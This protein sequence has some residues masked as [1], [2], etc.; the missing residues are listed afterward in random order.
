MFRAYL[1]QSSG[2]Q[3]PSQWSHPQRSTTVPQRATSN[4]TSKYTPYAVTRGLFSWRWA[5]R[6][7]KHV[8]TVSIINIHNWQWIIHIVASCW[9]SFFT[10]WYLICLTQYKDAAKS[11]HFLDLKPTRRP[12][13]SSHPQKA[14]VA[15]NEHTHQ[16][17]AF[18]QEH[19]IDHLTTNIYT[20]IYNPCA[21]PSAHVSRPSTIYSSA[22]VHRHKTKHILPSQFL[23]L[24][25]HFI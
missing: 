9:Y 19:Y 18:T 8:E 23:T 24:T 2:E 22:N 11:L 3:Q 21:H 4:T 1:C 15:T 5:Q 10:I 13:V 6:C 12:Q 14:R 25:T 20:A 7:P 16:S 17:P